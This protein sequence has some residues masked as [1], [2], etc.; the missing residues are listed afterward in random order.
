MG[1][2]SQPEPPTLLGNSVTPAFS[3]FL[4]NALKVLI[5]PKP[6]GM[7]DPQVVL[8]IPA[9]TQVKRLNPQEAAFIFKFLSEVLSPV[10]P[11][12]D[13]WGAPGVVSD[14]S[15]VVAPKS[16]APSF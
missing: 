12:I 3:N 7:G 4:R 16:K 5:S 15:G 13:H 14:H 11:S 6:H 10:A 2:D 9:Q 1:V 8:H